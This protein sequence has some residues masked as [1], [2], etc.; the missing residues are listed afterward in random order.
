MN[1]FTRCCFNCFLHLTVFTKKLLL[2]KKKIVFLQSDFNITE[3]YFSTHFSFVKN[4]AL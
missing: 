3:I 1:D 2:I 4:I